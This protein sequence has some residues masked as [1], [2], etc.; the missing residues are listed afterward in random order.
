MVPYSPPCKYYIYTLAL[1]LADIESH[2]LIWY[3]KCRYQ[4]SFVQLVLYFLIYLTPCIYIYIYIY[5]TYRSSHYNCLIFIPLFQ[6]G[7][8]NTRTKL[9]MVRSSKFAFYCSSRSAYITYR[10][11]YWAKKFA[12]C[13]G[14]HNMKAFF[15]EQRCCP[16]YWNPQY[17][18]V[19]NWAKAEITWRRLR[20]TWSHRHTPYQHLFLSSNCSGFCFREFN[21]VEN[22]ADLLL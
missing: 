6:F 21:L 13:T 5:I 9:H 18:G 4:L 3:Y 17:D 20:T 8:L 19:L 7:I 14:T 2:S 10:F 22:S 15:I 11:L 16:L 12:R 1:R